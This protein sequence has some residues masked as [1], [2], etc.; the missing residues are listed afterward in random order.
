VRGL[1]ATHNSGRL[2]IP[3]PN[4]VQYCNFVQRRPHY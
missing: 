2:A 1:K 4:A 3:A